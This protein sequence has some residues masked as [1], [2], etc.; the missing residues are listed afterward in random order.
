M[1]EINIVA[2]LLTVAFRT[3]C[4]LTPPTTNADRDTIVQD[5]NQFRESLRKQEASEL[6]E[7]SKKLIADMKA[8]RQQRA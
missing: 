1:N 2:A 8:K 4:P 3:A 5:Y 7:P 6:P